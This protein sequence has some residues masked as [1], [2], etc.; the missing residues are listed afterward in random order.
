MRSPAET[1]D[2]SAAWIAAM[3]VASDVRRLGALELGDG[4]GQRGAG[5]VVDA[6]VGV[7]RALVR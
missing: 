5:G 4:V 7:A 3:P 2:S 1:S 6:R